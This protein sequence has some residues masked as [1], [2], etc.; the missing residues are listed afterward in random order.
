[1]LCIFAKCFS[2]LI[3]FYSGVLILVPEIQNNN[4]LDTEE[5]SS[6]VCTNDDIIF[7]HDVTDSSSIP[8]SRQDHSNTLGHMS[9]IHTEGNRKVYPSHLRIHEAKLALNSGRA[10]VTPKGK[11]R[12]ARHVKPPCKDDCKRCHNPRLSRKEQLNINAAFWSLEDHFEQWKFLKNSLEGSAP[13]TKFASEGSKGEKL[14]SRVYY[15]IINGERKK[16]CKT[17]FKSTLSICDSWIDSAI[18][19]CSESAVKQDQR[20]RHNNRPKR[21]FKM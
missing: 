10:H 5:Y 12:Q 20:G 7:S 16:V 1:M 8:S 3:T 9:S 13:K 2:N 6:T 17:M 19:H 21:K 11:V 18:S 15:F 14:S 4:N